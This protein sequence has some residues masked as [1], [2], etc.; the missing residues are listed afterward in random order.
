MLR[1][2]IGSLR[3]DSLAIGCHP[4]PIGG[5]NPATLNPCSTENRT[6][7]QTGTQETNS[8]PM[9]YR[10]VLLESSPTSNV[11]IFC[12]AR[13]DVK[14]KPDLE[15]STHLGIVDDLQVLTYG[16]PGRRTFNIT[17]QSERG[18]AVVW[19]EKEQL[20]NISFSLGN[21]LEQ[22]DPEEE[23]S[24]RSLSDIPPDSEGDVEFKAARIAMQYDAGRKVFLFAAAGISSDQIEAGEDDPDPII[25]QFGFSHRQ[26]VRLAERGM[27]IV[28]AGRPICPYCHIAIDRGD[29]HLCERRNGHDLDVGS[30]AVEQIREEEEEEEN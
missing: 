26:G 10:G 17:V 15:Q 23:I 11:A 12:L 22:M 1:S 28:A 2:D 19:L 7:A 6:S 21:A 9:R 18:S 30:M 25:L 16:E 27:E 5:E 13:P 20:Y 14:E 4:S 8:R 3:P 24:D 29:E